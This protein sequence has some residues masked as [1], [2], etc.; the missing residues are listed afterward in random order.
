MPEQGR[1]TPGHPRTSQ[2]V[3]LAVVLLI[4][5]GAVVVVVRTPGREDGAGAGLPTSTSSA[6]SG[7]PTGPAL[8]PTD[9]PE[10]RVPAGPVLAALDLGTP[11]TRSGI[12][13]QMQ[14]LLASPDLGGQ[15]GATVLDPAT[16]ELLLDLDA[17]GGHVPASTTKVL[18]ALAALETLGPETRFRTTVVQAAGRVVLV[19]GGDPVLSQRVEV[20]ESWVY[21]ITRF[22]Q[23][24]RATADALLGSGTTSVRLGYAADLFAGPAVNPAW[25]PGYVPGGQVA[26]VSAL[27][28]D[29]G[30]TR[31]G[32]AQRSDD[33]AGFA[34][35]R[36]AA[37]LGAYG[38]RVEGAPTPQPT[39]RAGPQTALLASIESPTVAEIVGQT[40]T[41]SDNDGAEMLARHVARAEGIEPT[42][43][44]GGLAIVAVLERLGIPTDGLVLADGSG[45]SR[46]NRIAPVTLARALETAYEDPDGSSR[47]LL[48]GLPVAGF[49]GTL[50]SRFAD[51]Q[52]AREAGDV[53]AKTGYLSRVV[54]LAGYVVDADGRLLVFV[55]LADAVAPV[56]TLDAQRAIDQLAARLAACGCS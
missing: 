28:L 16:D 38:V 10:P 26:P 39:P 18:T 5:A 17:G 52:S 44:G 50:T 2:R 42:F 37:L 23:L 48:A 41:R 33:P 25:E 12:A 49:T 24:A 55:V 54:A 20:T 56:S 8:Q 35:D 34:A 27:S 32:V 21:P 30:R 46:S 6:T 47:S 22:D 53:R 31:V 9:E 4:I 1:A 43:A 51:P 15:V 14:P 3:V 40:L 29:G 13:A 36:F 19:G 7:Q 45:L 11:A